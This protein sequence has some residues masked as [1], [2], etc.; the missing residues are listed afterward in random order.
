MKTMQKLLAIIIVIVVCMATS[1]HAQITNVKLDDHVTLDR[2]YLGFLAGGAFRT[3]STTFFG[4]VDIGGMVTYRPAKWV[5]FSGLGV[6]KIDSKIPTAHFWAQINPHKKL[7]ISVGYMGTLASEQRP[8]KVT[9]DD[10]FITA[11]E[12]NVPGGTYNIK[13]VTDSVG[14][15]GFGLCVASRNTKLKEV[16]FK[17]LEYQAMFKYNWMKISGWYGSDKKF[18]SALTL[19]LP[20]VY[21][22][23]SWR[24]DQ[25]LANFICIK[26]GKN[27]DYQIISDN[28]YNFA[29]KTLVRS[30]TGFLKTFKS[31]NIANAFCISG[32]LGIT[33]KYETRSINAYVFIHPSPKRKH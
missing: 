8:K 3:D 11:T 32:L 5:A 2:V 14:K 4:S 9:G 29:T 31:P 17:S 18:G 12:N 15:F 24:Q 23:T 25:V 7:A 33:Y 10:Q 13:I 21:N 28:G 19:D 22:I 26:F 27:K 6:Y 30:E 1:A 16:D 20:R